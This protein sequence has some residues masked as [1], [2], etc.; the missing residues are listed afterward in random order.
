MPKPHLLKPW[1][2]WTLT[3]IMRNKRSSDPEESSSSL[4]TGVLLTKYS[5]TRLCLPESKVPS[6]ERAHLP[7][8]WTPDPASSGNCFC[9]NPSQA[10]SNLPWAFKVWRGEKREQ[11]QF[12]AGKLWRAG[13]LS[14]D[15]A[16][17]NQNGQTNFARAYQQTARIGF[18]SPYNSFEIFKKWRLFWD[19]WV[20]K[21]IELWRKAEIIY[22]LLND[23]KQYCS[24][25]K[26][27]LIWSLQVSTYLLLLTLFWWFIEPNK[28]KGEAEGGNVS[29]I[30]TKK[31]SCL[32]GSVCNT[33]MPGWTGYR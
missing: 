28:K 10:S 8:P 25:S 18:N 23:V 29:Q 27:Y 31:I 24:E 4:L 9:K 17:N 13:R 7:E 2:S 14:E 5:G 6:K 19:Y 12:L 33:E 1:L 32:G 15:D 22:I 30:I 11:I 20:L 26:L 3:K 21:L 16:H